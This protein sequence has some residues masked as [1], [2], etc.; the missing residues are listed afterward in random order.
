MRKVSWNNKTINHPFCRNFAEYFQEF[1][2]Q[3][4][5]MVDAS[6]NVNITT[7]TGV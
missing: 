4:V 2:A 7:A 1:A 3:F 6:N 5:L